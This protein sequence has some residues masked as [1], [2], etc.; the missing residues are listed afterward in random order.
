[1]LALEG[2]VVVALVVK[3]P[4]DGQPLAAQ[5][6][7]VTT[8]AMW[9]KRG[10]LVKQMQKVGPQ[11]CDRGVPGQYITLL[12][13]RDHAQEASEADAAGGGPGA[14]LQVAVLQ[15]CM[16]TRCMSA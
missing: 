14:A 13:H 2:L 5:S 6:I 10:E 12:C 9:T 3:R 7:R 15:T 1:M 8:R 16:V 11:V 4:T